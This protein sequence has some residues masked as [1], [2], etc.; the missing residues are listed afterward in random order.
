MWTDLDFIIIVAKRGYFVEKQQCS[1]EGGQCC[2]SEFLWQ[3]SG[4]CLFSRTT[5]QR[6]WW[7]WPIQ[8]SWPALPMVLWPGTLS[9]KFI[10]WAK[11]FTMLLS[12]I[13]ELV[14]RNMASLATT[15]FKQC[16]L[17]TPPTQVSG[18]SACGDTTVVL[19]LLQNIESGR[20]RNLHPDILTDLNKFWIFVCPARS[21]AQTWPRWPCWTTAWG[22]PARTVELPQPLSVFGLTLGP[23][24][25]KF[26]TFQTYRSL[27]LFPKVWECCQ[28][29]SG[30]LP[31]THGLQR[32][33]QENSDRAGAGG[34]EHGRPPERLHQ[35]GTDCLL[36]QMP[37]R[38]PRRRR[39]NP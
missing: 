28:Q 10:F 13:I 37:L 14:I 22:W 31:R 16:L 26:T 35:Q 8:W 20:N 18:F 27:H 34:W 1:M 23:G 15:G 36:C 29:W 30:A 6:K 21:V 9:H 39:W 38:R 7:L 4:Q 33:L 24:K 25:N 32:H 11:L 12:T 3:Q 5:F 17:N 2:P 19:L